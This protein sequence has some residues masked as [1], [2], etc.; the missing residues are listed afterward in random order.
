M[1]A[2]ARSRTQSPPVKMQPPML[3]HPGEG[4][5][6]VGTSSVIDRSPSLQA[7]PNWAPAFAGEAATMRCSYQP[8]TLHLNLSDR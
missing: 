3:H 2:M 5:G 6:P 1:C 7:R 8:P 4:R